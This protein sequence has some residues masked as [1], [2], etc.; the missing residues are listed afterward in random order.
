MMNQEAIQIEVVKTE[1]SRLDLVV[2]SFLY[3]VVKFF[4][5]VVNA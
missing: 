3:A 1:I 5:R 2:K 4:V